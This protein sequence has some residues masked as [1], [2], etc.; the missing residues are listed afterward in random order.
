MDHLGSPWS[1]IVLTL[2]EVMLLVQGCT[3]TGAEI[4]ILWPEGVHLPVCRLSYPVKYILG[5]AE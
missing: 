2:R 3:A 1:D 4:S 5:R